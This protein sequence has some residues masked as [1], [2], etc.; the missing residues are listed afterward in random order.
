MSRISQRPRLVLIRINTS[1]FPNSV[2]QHRTLKFSRGKMT[3]EQI[4]ESGLFS[5]SF[6]CSCPGSIQE[7]LM[8]EGRGKG[9]RQ[10]HPGPGDPSDRV[11]TCLGPQARHLLHPKMP[12]APCQAEA[13]LCNPRERL[14]SIPKMHVPRGSRGF[15]LALMAT[16]G[17]FR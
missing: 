8:T 12:L 4:G 9:L 17:R 2:F 3:R 5:D 14:G 1:N 6:T 15:S 13:Q 7:H 10:W 16:L 11:S